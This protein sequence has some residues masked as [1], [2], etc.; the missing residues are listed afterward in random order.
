MA[1]ITIVYITIEKRGSCRML[2]K[3]IVLTNLK[4]Q[5]RQCETR[6]YN[7]VGFGIKSNFSVLISVIPL[8]K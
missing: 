2:H 7:Y 6:K 8:N 1:E 4:F 3:N 5:Y